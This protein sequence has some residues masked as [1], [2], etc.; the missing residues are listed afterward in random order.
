MELQYYRVCRV[1]CRLC[2]TIVE[3]RNRS[4]N[5]S[6][7]GRILY[8]QCGKVGLDPA[9]LMPRILVML[10]ATFDDVEQLFEPWED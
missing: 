7:P 2:G 9:A 5:D 8:C 1:R 10:P 3:W 6:G 4:K